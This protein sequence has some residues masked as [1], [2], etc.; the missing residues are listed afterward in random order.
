MQAQNIVNAPIAQNA[1]TAENRHASAISLKLH[2]S[3]Q[4]AIKTI[5]IEHK[6]G[7]EMPYISSYLLTSD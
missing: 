5:A 2:S 1:N 6:R 7:N 4:K 3:Q